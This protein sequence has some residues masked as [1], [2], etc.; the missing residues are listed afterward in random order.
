MASARA[1][2]TAR[3]RLIGSPSLHFAAM[4]TG[5][6]SLHSAGK[7][8]QPN[9]PD[10]RLTNHCEGQRGVV[11]AV[12]M[13]SEPSELPEPTMENSEPSELPEP[14]MENSEPSG[15]PEPTMEETAL[16][17]GLGSVIRSGT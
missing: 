13:N 5:G 4:A 17:A 11:H 14:T 10:C 9:P 15:L 3:A 2:A 12:G 16:G 6:F 7:Q 1:R 8:K